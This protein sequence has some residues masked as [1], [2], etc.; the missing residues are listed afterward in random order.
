LESDLFQKKMGQAESAHPCDLCETIRQEVLCR[1]ALERGCQKIAFG[2][3]FDDVIETILTGVL[4]HG[5]IQTIMP[6]LQV[7]GFDEIE[8]ICPLYYVRENDITDWANENALPFLSCACAATTQ[9]QLANRQNAKEW[10]RAMQ[11]VNP[12]IAHHIFRS[13]WNV[14]LRH[15]ISYHCGETY[16]HFLDD[17]IPFE[18][19]LYS[20]HLSSDAS[21][22]H[23][24]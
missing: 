18:K 3:H 15:L 22:M 17:E 1:A 21:N 6:K 2:Y 10:I 16:H 20:E 7:H 14:D 24:L 13:I 8:Q 5:Q 4:Y 9:K 19:S 12:D 23:V 11:P